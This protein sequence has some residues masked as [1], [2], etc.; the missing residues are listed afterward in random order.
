VYLGILKYVRKLNLAVVFYMIMFSNLNRW[1]F[2]ILIITSKNARAMHREK[3]SNTSVNHPKWLFI[4][5]VIF[6][7]CHIFP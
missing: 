4:L 5:Y 3:N 7:K 1:L 2:V 6:N